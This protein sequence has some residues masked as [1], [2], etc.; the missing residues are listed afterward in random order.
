MYNDA[1]DLDFHVFIIEETKEELKEHNLTVN[2]VKWVGSA[3]GK[4]ALTWKE[5]EE[6]FKD[7]KYDSGYGGQEIAMDLVVVGCDWWLERHEYDGSERWEFKKLPIKNNDA[8]AFENITGGDWE[9]LEEM[10]KRK[11]DK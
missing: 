7:L 8:M 3:D 4:L 6:K 2:D 10:N 11:E 1:V 5:F 9:T